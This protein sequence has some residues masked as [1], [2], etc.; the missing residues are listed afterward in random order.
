[1][2][3]GESKQNS[4]THLRFQ[5]DS[6]LATLLSQE[7]SSSERALNELIDNAWDADAVRRNRTCSYL[8][9]NDIGLQDEGD[10]DTRVRRF[11]QALKTIANLAEVLRQ[12]LWER[13]R[14][15]HQKICRNFGYGVSDNMGFAC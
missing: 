8:F 10:F 2:S 15:V 5:H 11:E 7:Y 1:M 12:P 3:I 6:R 4:K 14:A 13:L 9:S